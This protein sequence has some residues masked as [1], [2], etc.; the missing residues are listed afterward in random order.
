MELIDERIAIK[1][2]AI[3]WIDY[4]DDGKEIN[5]GERER[6]REVIE[7]GAAIEILRAWY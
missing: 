7:R 5:Q 3:E 4:D 2:A 6:Q 1:T